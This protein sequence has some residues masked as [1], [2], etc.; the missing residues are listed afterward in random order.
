MHQ[1][2]LRLEPLT[3][4]EILQATCGRA[5]EDAAD[6]PQTV[7]G[8]STDTRR[9]SPGEMYIPLVGKNFDG[10]EFVSEAFARGAA[11]TLA[12]R[13]VE[14]DP[15]R[16]ILVD[17]TLTAWHR[18]AAHYRR[19]FA[20]PVVAIT[21]SYGKTT[22][23]DIV[24]AALRCHFLHVV[25]TA[26]NLNN[27]YGV[28]QTIQKIDHR[29]GAA[30]IEM[31]MRGPEQIRP[32]ARVSAPGV[33][34][35]TTIGEAHLELLGTQE[36]ICDAKAE[37]LD[38]LETDSVAVLPRDS[39]WFERLSRHVRGR[40]LTFGYSHEAD[41]RVLATQ[42][43]DAHAQTVELQACSARLT[44]PLPLPGPHNA[45][46]L[47]AAVAAILALGLTTDPLPDLPNHFEPSGRRH[48][49][50]DIAGGWHVLN[51]AYNAGPASTI[52]ALD[53]LASL[54]M[55]GRRAAVLADMLELG[56]RA[57]EFHLAVGRHAATILDFLITCGDLGGVIGRGARQ[58]GL[59]NCEHAV[60]REQ[61]AHLLRSWARPGDVVLVK[62][63]R[64]MQLD[65]L[66]DSLTG[67]IA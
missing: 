18:I 43:H 3:I 23:K 1:E 67:D 13:S 16:T 12:D 2:H 54:P 31:A 26:A 24:A 21:G 48:E 66:V 30:V 37:L 62:A 8:I 27:E 57:P 9:I 63:S 64:G 22:T 45:V 11:A 32:L 6:L 55:S 10:H 46:N 14:A 36:A 28:P 49:I 52:A 38:E 25:K 61:A 41:V 60:T 29:T 20:I 51:D 7:C 4:T 58:A 50:V 39:A 17:D 40:V 34:I 42:P 59:A 47:A 56:P 33:A 19:K 53:T 44:L 5:P 15:R 65:L 35:I